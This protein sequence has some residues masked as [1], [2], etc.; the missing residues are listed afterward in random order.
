MTDYTFCNNC[1]KHGHLFHQC[2]NPITSSGIIVYN[3]KANELMFLM[4]CRKDSLGYVDFI[5]GKYHLY[6]KRYIINIINEM[7]ISEKKNILEKEFDELWH[8]LWGDYI[9]IQ[10]KSEYKISKEKFNMLKLGI[11]LKN[12]EYNLVSLINE[13]STNWIDPEWGFPKG[14]RNLQEK[15]MSCAIREFEEETGCS[16]DALKIIYNLLPVE[17]LFTGSN[18][19]SYKHKYYI[20]YMD[21][22][23]NLNNYQKSEVSKIEWKTYKECMQHIRPYNQEK[24]DILKRVATIINNYLIY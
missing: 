7:T 3:N 11:K 21:D 22:T 1:G 17:E 18:Y 5:R 16:K 4:I 12:C 23:I 20:A 8:A 14:R 19:K 2:K 6:N 24:I 13:S 9:G 10:Y 15:D